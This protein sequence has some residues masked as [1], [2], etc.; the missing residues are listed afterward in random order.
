MCTQ[1]PSRSP[2]VDASS[3]NRARSTFATWYQLGSWRDLDPRSSAQLAGFGEDSPRGFTT[4]TTA[5]PRCTAVAEPAR[6]W[7]AT[8]PARAPNATARP[9]RRK[10]N[11][12]APRTVSETCG[13]KERSGPTMQTAST[14]RQGLRNQAERSLATANWTTKSAMKRVSIKTSTTLRSRSVPGDTSNTSGPIAV[15]S[16]TMAR[17][18]I[19]ASFSAREAQ[20]STV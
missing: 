5:G 10:R 12:S 2:A 7:T 6:L 16:A 11:T 1:S 20:S 19:T 4:V 18:P 9:T 8:A 15:P 3:E 13:R 17:N 14:M